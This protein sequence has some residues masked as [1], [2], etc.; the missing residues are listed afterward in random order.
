MLLLAALVG[1]LSSSPAAADDGDLAWSV[2]PADNE[3]GTS[4]ANF[5]YA[6]EPGDVVEDAIVVTNLGQAPLDLAVYAAD[7]FSTSAGHLDLLPADQPSVDLGTWVSPSSPAIAL[8]PGESA[9]VPFTIA[10]PADAAPGDHPGGIVTSYAHGDGTVR[11]DNRLGSRIHVR[12]AGEQV[13]GLAVSDVRAEHATTLDPTRPVAMTL[14]Y[15]LTN[16]GNVRTLAHEDVT[17]AGPGGV[18][19]VTR[20][21]L[22]EEL[23]PGASV[24]R[25]VVVDGVW[26]LVRLGADLAVVPEAVDGALGE[27]VDVSTS[28]WA[29][30]WGALVVLVLVV[31][32]AVL[33]G[34]RRGRRT[35][36]VIPT[37]SGSGSP[38]GALRS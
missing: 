27:P 10:V 4:R 17:V 24:E 11:R 19:A 38:A 25:Q 23:L 18:A 29:V 32:G 31:G 35:S 14:T 16:T 15:T 34:V 20:S 13:V 8:D 2:R 26:P 37:T 3:H 22:V 33:I 1:L 7:G 28:A 36:R 9:E 21:A 12:V 30:P 6:V 5:A